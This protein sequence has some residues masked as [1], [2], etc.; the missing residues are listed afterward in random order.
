MNDGQK[1]CSKCVLPATFPGISFDEHGVCS[2][3]R[4]HE[5]RWRNWDAGLSSKRKV[6]EQLCADAKRKKRPFDVL[7]PLSGGK[8]SMYVLYLAVKEFGLK[9]LAYTLETTAT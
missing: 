8:D 3:C 7:V 1:I 5:E 2:V 6:L 4:A 9:P